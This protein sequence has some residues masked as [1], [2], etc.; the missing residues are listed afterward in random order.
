MRTVR[1]L[2]RNFSKG[3]YEMTIRKPFRWTKRN[4]IIRDALCSD[5]DKKYILSMVRDNNKDARES[6][7]AMTLADWSTAIDEVAKRIK[8]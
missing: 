7:L 3:L 6:E 5:M 1:D 8:D 2:D 4:V